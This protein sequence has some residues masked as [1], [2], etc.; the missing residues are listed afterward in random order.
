MASAE[1]LAKLIETTVRAVLSGIQGNGGSIGGGSG[2]KRILDPKGMN[3]VDAFSGKE[4]QWREWAFQL[5]VAIKA[6]NSEVADIMSRCE[7]DEDAHKL[8]DVEL[9]FEDL[10]VTKAAGELYDILCLC[11]KGDPLIL[12]QGVT[13]MNGFEAWG[14]LYR[15]HNPVTPAR[16]LQA[17]IAVM[18]PPKVKDVRELPNEI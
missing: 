3:R 9:E 12:V 10:A 16:A 7:T 14:R 1:E 4:S 15:R 2:N 8:E 6:M 5:R 18:V 11:L 17:M 13:S